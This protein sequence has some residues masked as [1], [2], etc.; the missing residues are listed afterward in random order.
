MSL[1]SIYE[2]TNILQAKITKVKEKQMKNEDSL[3]LLLVAS[4]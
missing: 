4:W 1:I 3:A 2:I